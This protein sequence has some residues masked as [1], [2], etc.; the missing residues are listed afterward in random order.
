MK[1]W[2]CTY[3]L[4]DPFGFAQGRLL[5]ELKFINSVVRKNRTTEKVLMLW[6][7]I[8]LKNDYMNSLIGE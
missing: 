1:R 8:T 4:F 2:A 5:G 3:L 6:N 7:S